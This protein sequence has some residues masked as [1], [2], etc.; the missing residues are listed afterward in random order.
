MIGVALEL[1]E[2]PVLD[3]SDER[4]LIGA[5]VRAGG[6][7]GLDHSTISSARAS[8]DGGIVRR[9]AFAVLRL[10]RRRT[11]VTP[12]TGRSRGIAPRNTF[13]TSRAACM[14]SAS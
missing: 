14:P 7:D 8:A 1:E 5:V 9:N 6:A 13:A 12:S 10:M 3:G 2:T 11:W 4:A